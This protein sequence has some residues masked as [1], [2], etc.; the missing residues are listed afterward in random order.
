MVAVTVEGGYSPELDEVTTGVPVRLLFDRQE[1]G[2]CSSRAVIPDFYVNQSLTTL[3]TSAPTTTRRLRSAISASRLGLQPRTARVVRDGNEP[4]A[5]LGYS[6]VVPRAN[7]Y[8]PTA[9]GVT[10][11][12]SRS[13]RAFSTRSSG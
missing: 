3:K 5:A 13:P 8:S 9:S 6:L 10:G 12:S 2:D 7:S 4:V 11:W 1:S